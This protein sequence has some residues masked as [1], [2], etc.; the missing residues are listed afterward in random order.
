MG[1]AS[2]ES[3]ETTGLVDSVVMKQICDQRFERM[4]F[5]FH[6]VKT[7]ALILQIKN[8]NTLSQTIFHWTR[9]QVWKKKLNEKNTKPS[10][11]KPENY[12]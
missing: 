5:S 10:E 11:K 8:P 3:L 4:H 2:F 6:F 9:S 12:D 1:S 7:F